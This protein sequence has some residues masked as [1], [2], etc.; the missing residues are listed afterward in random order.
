MIYPTTPNLQ[1]E[2]LR[3]TIDRLINT[4]KAY[5]AASIARF[6]HPIN[7]AITKKGNYCG[8]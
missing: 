4:K 6:T 3:N 7:R 1:K 2:S 5:S 8:I